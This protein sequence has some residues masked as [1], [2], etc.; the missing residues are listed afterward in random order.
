MRNGLT[1]FVK[2]TGSGLRL[3]G[4]TDPNNV[5]KPSSAN[6]RNYNPGYVV[7]NVYT[8]ACDNPELMKID[9]SIKGRAVVFVSSDT[10]LDPNDLINVYI[11]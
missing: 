8:Y 11:N 3:G 6:F 1:S 2:R 9:P 4:Y 10:L 7:S 5:D